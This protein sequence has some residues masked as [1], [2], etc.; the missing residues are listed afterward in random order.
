MCRVKQFDKNKLLDCHPEHREGSPA[1]E[2]EA[3]DWL[4]QALRGSSLRAEWQTI[5]GFVIDCIAKHPMKTA[6]GRRFFTPLKRTGLNRTFC[7]EIPASL[8]G[9]NYFPANRVLSPANRSGRTRASPAR[10]PRPV[11]TSIASYR[12]SRPW[13]LAGTG[14]R[15]HRILPS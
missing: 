13:L 9:F 8:S 6:I 11:S 5:E 12:G 14:R 3:E 7:I 15:R 4:R 2:Q 10:K 1:T